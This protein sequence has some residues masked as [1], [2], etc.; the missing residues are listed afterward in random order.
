[1]SAES[2]ALFDITVTPK[3][4]RSLVKLQDGII[5]VFLHSPPSEGKAN[6]ECIEVISKTLKIAKSKVSI[7]KGERGRNKKI[8]VMGMSI[9]EVMER[10]GS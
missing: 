5:R 3:S 10:I 2:K 8:L 9:D 6:R 7:E 1:M 4:S